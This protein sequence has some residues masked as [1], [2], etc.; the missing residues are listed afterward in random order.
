M[1]HN[2]APRHIPNGSGQTTGTG[3]AG[4]CGSSTVGGTASQINLSG[5]GAW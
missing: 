4:H 1:G 5:K 3:A 2:N